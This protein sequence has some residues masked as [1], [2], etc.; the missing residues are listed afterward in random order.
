MTDGQLPEELELHPVRL[1]MRHRFRGISYREAVLIR[2]PSGWG[3]FS[4][5]PE[6]PPEVAARWL[7]SA[8]ESACGVWPEARRDR[9]PVNV[10]IPAVDPDTAF[11]LAK[12][13]G[14]LT[15]K[16]KVAEAGQ[17]ESDDLARVEAVREALG[18]GGRIRV[19]ANAAWDVPTAISRIEVLDRFHLEYV[20]QPVETIGEMREVRAAVAVP[21]AADELV[22]RLSDPVRVAEEEAADVVVVKVQPLGGVQRV[23]DVVARLGLPAV[24]SSALDTSVGMAAG[25]AAA[26]ALSDLP[27]ACGLGTV[28]LFEQDVVAEPLVPVDGMVEVRRPEPEGDLLARHHPGRER[29][30]EMVGRMR[31]AAQWLT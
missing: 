22:R 7:A 2:G 30:S 3:E 13:S 5:F 24:V 17:A 10:T 6:Y 26:A 29:E 12:V 23:L 14:A 1:P 9:I 11:H 15:A 8:L 25:V 31:E 27:Y 28:S 18:S 4:P 21:I 19:D 16:V 20:E